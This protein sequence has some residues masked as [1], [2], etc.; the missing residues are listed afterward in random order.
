MNRFDVGDAVRVDIPDKSDPDYERWHGCEG[1]VL[2]VTED[3]AGI[4][5]GD[6]RDNI[7]YLVEAECGECMHFRWRDLRPVQND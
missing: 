4:E 7:S 1:T 3:A 2:E 6:P 5:T